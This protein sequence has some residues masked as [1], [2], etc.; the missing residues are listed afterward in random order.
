MNQ[1]DGTF[2][3]AGVEAEIAYNPDGIARSGMGVAAGDLNGDGR[4]DFVVTNFDNEYHALYLNKGK[5]P[6]EE[7][8][9]SSGLARLTR[10]YVGWG[11]G[12][13]DYDNNGILDLLEINGHIQPLISMSNIGVSYR[14]PPL[15]LSNDGSAKFTPVDAGPAF[16]KGYLGRGL[17]IEDF[18]NDGAV[19]AIFVNLNG[20][21]VLLHNTYAGRNAWLGVSLRGTVSNRDA[22]GARLRLHNG[23]SVLT[24]WIT[25][26]FLSSHDRRV[27]FGLGPKPGRLSLEIDWPNGCKQT[28]TQLAL[29]RYQTI[30]EPA[31]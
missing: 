20:S 14:E 10:P 16:R 22:I 29:R 1:H 18:D 25:G 28:V 21:P 7:S 9:V 17:A 4:P 13:I 12:L 27:V 23:N 26:S 6:F 15:L 19:D 11:V 8:T 24:R 2:R 5:F 30:I 3:D 31:R